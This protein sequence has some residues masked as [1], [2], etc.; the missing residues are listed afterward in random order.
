M[1]CGWGVAAA[2]PALCFLA[3]LSMGAKN[4]PQVGEFQVAAPGLSAGTTAGNIVSKR[5]CSSES[6][7]SQSGEGSC[8]TSHFPILA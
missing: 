8:S 4:E 1:R 6:A 7:N 3:V 2:T 5:V